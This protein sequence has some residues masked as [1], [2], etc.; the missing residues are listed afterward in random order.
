[1]S[2]YAL[3]RYKSAHP[4]DDA[5]THPL[6]GA[7][8]K[9]LEDPKYKTGNAQIDQKLDEFV[10]HPVDEKTK[11]PI[12]HRPNVIPCVG[13][14]G[15]TIPWMQRHTIRAGDVVVFDFYFSYVPMDKGLP[16]WKMNIVAMR[17]MRQHELGASRDYD[18][19]IEVPAIPGGADFVVKEDKADS[20]A[21]LMPPDA[22]GLPML[23]APDGP[24]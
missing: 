6:I 2:F 17:V 8:I 21:A 7:L 3:T 16:H 13:P 20:L 19:A 1:L 23:P 15:K 10:K 24:N 12:P 22:I 18:P 14:S 4:G 9:R 5:L 11:Q